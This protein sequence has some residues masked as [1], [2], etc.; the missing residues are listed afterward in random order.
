MAGCPPDLQ[1]HIRRRDAEATV[2]SHV[3]VES[4]ATLTLCRMSEKR[5][6]FGTTS[7]RRRSSETGDKARSFARFGTVL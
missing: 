7:G 2:C 1:F 4:P 6:N 5:P 3:G